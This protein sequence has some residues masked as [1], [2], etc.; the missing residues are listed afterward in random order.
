MGKLAI[1]FA[2]M[3]IVLVVT[4]ILMFPTPDV[5]E[6][7]PSAL[8]DLHPWDEG[9]SDSIRKGRNE[10][11]FIRERI[12]LAAAAQQHALRIR[13]YGIGSLGLAFLFTL[14]YGYRKI[15]NRRSG[16]IITASGHSTVVTDQGVV[17]QRKTIISRSP[18]GQIRAVS[19]NDYANAL[20]ELRGF[21]A[22]SSLDQGKR[23]AANNLLTGAESEI[24]SEKPN[25]QKMIDYAKGLE[26]II[27]ASGSVGDT[28]GN[29]IRVLKSLFEG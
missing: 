29:A 18:G 19:T 25:L 7:M 16:H 2:A 17:D 24:G 21:V 12:V 3:G 14:T 10:I 1:A 6:F 11:E 15:M 20:R 28:V 27:S 13:N 23:N 9:F 5:S 8:P 26:E 4:G 22:G